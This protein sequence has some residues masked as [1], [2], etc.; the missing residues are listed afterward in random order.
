MICLQ[1]ITLAT[2]SQN[3]FK[4]R[5]INLRNIITPK[6]NQNH[7]FNQYSLIKNGK[8]QQT[9]TKLNHL[10]NKTKIQQIGNLQEVNHTILKM[11]IT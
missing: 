9:V 1:T 5:E 10:F 11:K 8:L 7:Y 4:Q 2:Q 6:R 3:H